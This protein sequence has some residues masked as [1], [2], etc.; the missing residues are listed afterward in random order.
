MNTNSSSATDTCNN[1]CI[2]SGDDNTCVNDIR[3]GNSVGGNTLGND[4]HGKNDGNNGGSN[5]LNRSP[6]RS[7]S[8]GGYVKSPKKA[9]ECCN[10]GYYAKMAVGLTPL[11]LV[12][13]YYSKKVFESLYNTFS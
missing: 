6:S 2:K 1:S 4:S 9:E 7:G 13:G 3:G 12:G 8:A 10:V 5:N 11:I